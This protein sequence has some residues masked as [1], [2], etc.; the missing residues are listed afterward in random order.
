MITIDH[1][2][3]SYGDG[4]EEGKIYIS[5]EEIDKDYVINFLSYNAKE[6]VFDDQDYKDLEHRET[7][8][9]DID[10]YEENKQLIVEIDYEHYHYDNG[11]RTKRIGNIIEW[12]TKDVNFLNFLGQCC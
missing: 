5:F 3:M 11:H 10:F 12:T 4:V 2:S 8:F 7:Y 9:V 6:F 1:R